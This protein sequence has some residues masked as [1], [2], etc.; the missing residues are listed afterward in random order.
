MPAKNSKT[1]PA[2]VGKGTGVAIVTPFTKTG[3]VD[4]KGLEKIVQHL[5]K[6]KVEYIV[7]MGTTGESATLSKDEKYEVTR[8]IVKVANG[9]VPIILGIGG[10]N[11]AEVIHSLDSTD[12]SGISAILSVAPSYNRPN[13]EGLYLHFKAVA[14]A[15]PL[16]V[17]LYNVPGRT[18]CNMTDETT[19]RLANDFEE[20][21]GIKEASGN[22]AQIMNII[23]NRPK[24]FMVISGDDLITLPILACGGDGVI[25]VVANAYPKDFS[26][27]TRQSIAGNYDAARKLHYKLTTI[28]NLLFADGSPGGIKAALE[29]MGLCEA[30]VRLPLAPINKKIYDAIKEEIK[31]YK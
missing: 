10:N 1:I 7:A 13:Q 15:A 18:A 24:N 16:P 11:T 25:S 5:I 26:E 20:I 14:Q 29:I 17:I 2:R 30:H 3:S 9:R 28:T 23:K 22:L 12:L 8:H 6:G 31:K 27:M 19:L 4:L 21:I